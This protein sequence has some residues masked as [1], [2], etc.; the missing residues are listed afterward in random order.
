MARLEFLASLYLKDGKPC[1]PGEMVEATLTAAGK[2]LRKG[3]D[4]ARAIACP[5]S[6]FLKFEGPKDPDKMWKDG[7]FTF[8]ALVRIKN[9]KIL[10]TRS[11]FN[12]WSA[13]IFVDYDDRV[14]NKEEVKELMVIAGRDIGFGTWR[15]KFGRFSVNN[16]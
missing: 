5:E 3:K 10:R 2:T 6:S 13:D 9:V 7:S 4:V 12:K 1:I 16:N 14:L 11:V 8:Q 15:P